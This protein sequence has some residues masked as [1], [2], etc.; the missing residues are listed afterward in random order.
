MLKQAQIAADMISFEDY[1]VSRQEE[2]G[3]HEGDGA[4][5]DRDDGR[6]PTVRAARGFVKADVGVQLVKMNLSGGFRSVV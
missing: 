1:S 4:E 3:E 5:S 6:T 2:H